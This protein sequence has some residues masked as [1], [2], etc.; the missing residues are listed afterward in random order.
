MM[1]MKLLFFGLFFCQGILAQPS[2]DHIRILE[3]AE[4]YFINQDF[5]RALSHYSKVGDSI[6][7]QSRRNF[8]KVYAQMG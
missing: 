4:Y 8:S 3:W 6:P 7:L 1:K 2:S 5:E